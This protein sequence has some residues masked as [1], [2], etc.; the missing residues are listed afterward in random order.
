MNKNIFEIPIITIS[1]LSGFCT[2]SGL[3]LLNQKQILYFFDLYSLNSH[4]I[5]ILSIIA[6]VIFAKFISKSK[7]L[8]TPIL[9]NA[10][11]TTW[12]IIYSLGFFGLA[13]LSNIIVNMLPLAFF[14]DL[15]KLY[16]G[17]FY[18]SKDHFY[19][20]YS[21]YFMSNFTQ[22]AFISFIFLEKYKHTQ[23]YIN[24]IPYIILCIIS[25][26]IGL[27]LR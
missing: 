4:Y 7:Y 20:M 6:G 11:N 18:K 26:L 9:S 1:I 2:S 22:S 25:F 12:L 8:L 13:N 5:L 19:I 27:S 23:K 15:C 21:L 17:I 3:I 16:Y 10:D 24:L 14:P